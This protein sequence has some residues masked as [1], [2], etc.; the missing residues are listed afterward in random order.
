MNRVNHFDLTAD[1]P[2][3]AEVF[4]KSVFGWKFTKWD[5]PMDYWMIETGK[6]EG[7]NGG[8]G[9]KGNGEM[10]AS[11]TITVK[12]IDDVLAKIK[13]KGGKIVGKKVAIP[14]VGW[15]AVFEDPEGNK[16]GLM[17]ED[18]KAR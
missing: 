3:K 8:L 17:Q 9:K 18:K 2:K 6:G 7:I 1:N 15:F 5:G 13:D 4:Y 14:S 16:L 11:M 12:S 10:G